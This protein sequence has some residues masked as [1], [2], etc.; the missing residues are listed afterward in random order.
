MKKGQNEAAHAAS[1]IKSITCLTGI[2]EGKLKKY[3]SENN[4]FNVLEHPNTIGISPQQLQ[5]IQVLNEFISTYRILKLQENENRMVFNSLKVS[6][7]YFVSLL[8]GIKD[9]EKFMAIFLDNGNHLIEIRTFSEGS[10]DESPIY[11]RM[12]LKAALDCDCKAIICPQ[13]PG[14]KFNSV[15]S[16]Y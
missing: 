7:E 14:W 6:G 9:R 8:S 10:I 4:V 1:F 5:K 3:A 12:I 2:A 11:P 16:G 13:P 15:Y